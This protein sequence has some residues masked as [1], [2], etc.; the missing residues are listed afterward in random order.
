MELLG[1]AFT[2]SDECVFPPRVGDIRIY[3][4]PCGR[5]NAALTDE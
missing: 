3:W 1:N 5:E 4:D 2:S